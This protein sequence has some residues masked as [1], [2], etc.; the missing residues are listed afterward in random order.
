MTNQVDYQILLQEIVRTA[1]KAA[2]SAKDR[3]DDKLLF[4]YYDI[5]DVIKT[6]AEI[7]DI[8]LDGIG[9]EKLNIDDLLK[10][11]VEIAKQKQAA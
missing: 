3:E 6:Q 5:L 9:M 10:A 11:S 4:A 8:P 2:I 1:S 7:M